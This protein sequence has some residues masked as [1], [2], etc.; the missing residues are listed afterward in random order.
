[1][2][3]LS[4]DYWIQM[5]KSIHDKMKIAIR[6]VFPISKYLQSGLQ[7]IINKRLIVFL[8]SSQFEVIY[9]LN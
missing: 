2:K 8:G 6:I 4:T 9:R 7:T 3:S 5:L 1:M